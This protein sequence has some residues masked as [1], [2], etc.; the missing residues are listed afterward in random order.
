MLIK[1]YLQF[2]AVSNTSM[3]LN[4]LITIDNLQYHVL[5]CRVTF[6]E[7]GPWQNVTITN[8]T[9]SD[10]GRYKCDSDFKNI[11][12]LNPGKVIS[13]T[14]FMFLSNPLIFEDIYIF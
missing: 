5:I 4:I 13:I 8:V 11:R 6:I 12:V 3:Y 1:M 9:Y 10:S 2:Y 7:S 14:K